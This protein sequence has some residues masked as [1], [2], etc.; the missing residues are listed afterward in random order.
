MVWGRNGP[1]EGWGHWEGP[2]QGWEIVLECYQPIISP[3]VGLSPLAGQG[4]AIKGCPPALDAG[5]IQGG[6]WGEQHGVAALPWDLPSAL[7]PRPA[8]CCSLR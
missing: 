4:R 7:P 5:G 3:T 8:S 1:R 2:G 6:S